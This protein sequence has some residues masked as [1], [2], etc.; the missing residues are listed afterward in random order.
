MGINPTE[1]EEGL[2]TVNVKK[3]RDVDN[4]SKQ[5]FGDKWRENRR[6]DY[7]R[8]SIDITLEGAENNGVEDEQ[9]IEE[10]EI[11]CEEDNIQSDLRV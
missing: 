1:I 11:I 5:H 10:E 2:V 6:L 3:I 4:L 7:Y 9:D 8:R